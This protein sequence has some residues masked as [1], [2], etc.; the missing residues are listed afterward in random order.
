MLAGK[1]CLEPTWIITYEKLPACPLKSL[2]PTSMS[3]VATFMTDR[4]KKS[5][6]CLVTK[7]EK[8]FGNHKSSSKA[9]NS[10]I[11]NENKTI[12]KLKLLEE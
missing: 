3:L 7:T 10:S 6:G 8:I 5:L 2:N 9:K 4:N 1:N 11:T 12:A